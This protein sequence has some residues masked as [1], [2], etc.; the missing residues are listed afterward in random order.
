MEEARKQDFIEAVEKFRNSAAGRAFAESMRK[1]REELDRW[2][3]S[4]RAQ[5]VEARMDC[6]IIPTTLKGKLPDGKAFT[7]RCRWDT[8]WFR[9]GEDYWNPEWRAEI[10]EWEF[11]EAGALS[12]EE[13]GDVFER[14]LALYFEETGASTEFT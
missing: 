8:C 7:L 1:R 10:S 3:E 14:L 4:L 13:I 11:P 5:G 2:A 9:V 12:V 6:Y